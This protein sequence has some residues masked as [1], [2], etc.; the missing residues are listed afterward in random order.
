MSALS[1]LSGSNK[2]TEVPSYFMSG[3]INHMMA[4]APKMFNPTNTGGIG[5]ILGAALHRG[6]NAFAKLAQPVLDY[7]DDGIYKARTQ[8]LLDRQ[9]IEKEQQQ[10]A[11]AISSG[12]FGM[13]GLSQLFKSTSTVRDPVT[14]DVYQ[15]GNRDIYGRPDRSAYGSNTLSGPD[16][17]LRT[18]ARPGLPV[19]TRQVPY[20][21]K[22]IENYQEND[23]YNYI[24]NNKDVRKAFESSTAA[25]NIAKKAW[26]ASKGAIDYNKFDK[27][28]YQDAAVD[29]A[30]NYWSTTGQ[31]KG[32]VMPMADRQRVVDKQKMLEEE[33]LGERP[34]RELVAN[35]AQNAIFDRLYNKPTQREYNPFSTNR[36]AGYIPRQS[37][38]GGGLRGLFGNRRPLGGGG[39]RSILGG[40]FR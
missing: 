36:F 14:G 28:A 31:S 17:L 18:A 10:I 9:R 13:D 39:L 15:T 33:Y 38:Y 23:Y 29:Y 27:K 32:H 3:I 26:D 25:K 37:F 7:A 5:G 40:L 8:N 30:R 1:E 11:D 12:K 34:E 16:S 6:E 22:D 2:D 35:G 21:Y 24:R 20:N 4:A 19:Y